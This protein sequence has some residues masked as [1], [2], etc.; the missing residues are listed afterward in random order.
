[1][2]YRTFVQLSQGEKWK[3]NQVMGDGVE[4]ENAA[5]DRARGRGIIAGMERREEEP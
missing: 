5:R 1:M 4:N 3:S 2:Y